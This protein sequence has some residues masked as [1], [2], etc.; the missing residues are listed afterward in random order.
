M[1]TMFV[2]FQNY[3]HQ[4]RFDDLIDGLVSL[5]PTVR[6]QRGVVMQIDDQELAKCIERIIDAMGGVSII[7]PDLVQTP[8]ANK[9]DDPAVQAGPGGKA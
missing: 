6:A 2:V 9:L 3:Y 4:A 8:A 7:E 5:L 1:K